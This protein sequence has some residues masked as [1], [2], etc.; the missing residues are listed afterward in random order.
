MAAPGLFTAEKTAALSSSIVDVTG[1]PVRLSGIVADEAEV[2][3]D[4]KPSANIP[5]VSSCRPT[6][7]LAGSSSVVTGFA[8]LITGPAVQTFH[9]SILCFAVSETARENRMSAN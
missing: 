2:L 1:T 4:S 5:Q 9:R 3:R 8:P 7:S 6:S